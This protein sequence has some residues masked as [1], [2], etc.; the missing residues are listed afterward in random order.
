M[1]KRAKQNRKRE[2]QNGM[3]F[4]PFSTL[5][6]II[7][8]FIRWEKG[9]QKDYKKHHSQMAPTTNEQN[10]QSK[11]AYAPTRNT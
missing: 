1:W 6:R 8:I 11:T 4:H 9:K 3:F 7:V 5:K 2:G 10:Q